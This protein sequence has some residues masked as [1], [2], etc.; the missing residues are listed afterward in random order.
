MERDLRTKYWEWRLGQSSCNLRNGIG[1]RSQ[2]QDG[3]NSFWGLTASISGLASGVIIN[4]QNTKKKK[5][6]LPKVNVYTH[7]N[8][9]NNSTFTSSLSIHFKQSNI[10]ILSPLLLYSTDKASLCGT[11]SSQMKSTFSLL[12]LQKK[13]LSPV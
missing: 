8:R 4:V 6:K 12:H 11:F 2:E 5:K 13:S 10:C 9:I 1:P 7:F 3:M